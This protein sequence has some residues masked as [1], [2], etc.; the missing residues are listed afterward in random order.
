M[1]SVCAAVDGPTPMHT[2]VRLS[3][4]GGFLRAHEIERG[5]CRR[6]VGKKEEMYWGIGDIL[7]MIKLKCV[8]LSRNY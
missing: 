1:L 2:R 5:K 3:R 8:K 7:N 6:A 4:L